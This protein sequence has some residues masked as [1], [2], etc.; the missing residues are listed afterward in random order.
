MSSFR[1]IKEVTY[2]YVL[3]TTRN[4]RSETGFEHGSDDWFTRKE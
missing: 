3:S 2:A 4:Y 1:N